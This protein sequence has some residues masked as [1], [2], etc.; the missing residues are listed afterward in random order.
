[1]PRRCAA[2]NT[3]LGFA[4]YQQKESYGLG[5]TTNLKANDSVKVISHDRTVTKA[6]AV[7]NDISWDATLFTPNIARQ[8]R[9][10]EY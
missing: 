8:D 3:F 7:K 4:G 1:M 6:E 5:Y 9:L 10:L 2:T